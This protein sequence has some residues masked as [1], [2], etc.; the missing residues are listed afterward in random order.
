MIATTEP[1]GL[2]NFAIA[3]YAERVAK[4][5]NVFAGGT[6]ADV[7]GLVRALGG[8]I[9]TSR[10]FLAEEALSV[11]SPGDFTVHLPP[12]TSARRD[13]FTIAHELGH[14]FLHYRLPRAVGARE[15][16][17]GGRDRAETEANF[18]AASLL[19]PRDLFTE[20]FE[21]FRRNRDLVAQAFGVSPVAVDVRCQVLGL[22]A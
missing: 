21:K 10:S 17:R 4:E 15:Y 16:G 8:S 2:S 6:A 7:E 22:T 20:T 11:R 13:R 14:Y 12:M 1:S 18:F 3:D 19:M 5:H 9:D